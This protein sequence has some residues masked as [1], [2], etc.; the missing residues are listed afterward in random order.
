MSEFFGDGSRFIGAADNVRRQVQ[1]PLHAQ[2]GR[3][4]PY[5]MPSPTTGVVARPCAPS[6]RG[7]QALDILP[8]LKDGDSHYWRSMSRTEKDI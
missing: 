6:K 7:D 5:A 4:G 2:R 1:C 8:A 3:S